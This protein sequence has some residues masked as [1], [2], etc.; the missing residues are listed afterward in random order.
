MSF[1]LKFLLN[2]R[3][4]K[5]LR[6]TLV[7]NFNRSTCPSLN[8]NNFRVYI[9]CVYFLVK[10]GILVPGGF[11][12]RGTE[13]MINAAEWAR[14]NNKPFWGICLGFQ[15]AVIEYCRN[16]LN[17]ADATSSEFN[18]DTNNPVVSSFNLWN[19]RFFL[20]FKF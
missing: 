10:S 5:S 17:L 19:L 6:D 12:T 16:V 1:L 7:N 13:G 14:L 20:L 15:C 2:I 8:A 11:G 9:F 3:I 18:K 4:Y